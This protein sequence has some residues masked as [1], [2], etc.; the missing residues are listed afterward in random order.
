[1]SWLNYK[2]LH[3]P[4]DQTKKSLNTQMGLLATLSGVY[5]FFITALVLSGTW[6]KNDEYVYLGLFRLNGWNWRQA[7]EILNPASQTAG[8]PL[9]NLYTSPPTHKV[10]KRLYLFSHF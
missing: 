10:R 1:M 3:D 7:F 5:A 2:P 6:G 9:S 8:R 4:D